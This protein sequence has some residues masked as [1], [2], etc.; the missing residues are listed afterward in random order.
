MK[1]AKYR[2]ERG[3]PIAD[4]MTMMTSS[5]TGNCLLVELNDSEVRRSEWFERRWKEHPPFFILQSP[6]ANAS[7]SSFNHTNVLTS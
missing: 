7:L 4:I 3:V 1:L 5:Q 6:I 2:I